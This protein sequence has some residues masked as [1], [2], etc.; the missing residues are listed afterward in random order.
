MFSGADERLSGSPFSIMF[1]GDNERL[2]GNPFVF[3]SSLSVL[4][5]SRGGTFGILWPTCGHG[6]CCVFVFSMFMC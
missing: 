2:S 6:V 3:K 4:N 1:S 5:L